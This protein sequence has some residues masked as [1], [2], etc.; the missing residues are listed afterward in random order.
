MINL[1]IFNHQNDQIIKVLKEE[2]ELIFFSNLLCAK[3]TCSAQL[4][5][6]SR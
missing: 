2:I 3:F 5:F 4:L 1:Y 6:V